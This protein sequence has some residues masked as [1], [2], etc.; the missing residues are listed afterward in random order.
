MNTRLS[1]LILINMFND[2]LPLT[3]FLP[4][5]VIRPGEYYAAKGAFVVSTLL[6]SC[7]AVCLW[8]SVAK[9]AGMNHFLL[10]NK[11][12]A[13]D[14]PVSITEAGRYGV[15]AMELMI[16][17]MMGLGAEKKRLK[18]KAFGGGNVLA[19]VST[20]NFNCVGSVNGRFIREFLKTEGIPLESE[21][22]GGDLG[23]VIRFRTDT[24]A[25]YRRFIRKVS[26]IR[27]EKQ[28]LSFWK[29]SIEQHKIEE[30]KSILFK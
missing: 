7:V 10:A 21:D 8:D 14:L 18:A 2:T 13:R 6:G 5:V 3:P 4:T 19:S 24:Y 20:D 26:T 16:N 11:R 1:E 25:V 28:E 9:V 12:Y 17:E 27:V 23:R 22:L 15:Q 30:P 29:Q